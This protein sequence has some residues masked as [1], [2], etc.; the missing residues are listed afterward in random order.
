[1]SET[2]GSRL[3]RLRQSAGLSQTRLAAAAGVPVTTLRNWER[4]RRIPLATAVPRLADSLGISA[5]EVLGRAG[6]GLTQGD[7][8]RPG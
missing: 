3:A 7:Q 5:D 8:V 2:F 4:G 6:S 1:M